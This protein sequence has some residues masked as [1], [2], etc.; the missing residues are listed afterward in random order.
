MSVSDPGGGLPL[1]NHQ[2]DQNKQTPTRSNPNTN[3]KGDNGDP[4]WSCKTCNK[5]TSGPEIPM[6]QCSFCDSTYCL[7]CKK[8]T[9]SKYK[10]LGGPDTMWLCSNTCGVAT[11][12]AI[13]QSKRGTNTDESELENRLSNKIEEGRT[14]QKNFR[15]E[16]FEKLSS[17][18]A[19]IK[20][21]NTHIEQVPTQ[22]AKS[23]SQAVSGTIPNPEG[24]DPPRN[25][26][27]R[28]ILRGA[29]EDQK[30]EDN[31]AEERKRSI[32]I[33]K[34]GESKKENRE[35]RLKEDSDRVKV[36]LD[37][38]KV[39]GIEIINTFRLGIFNA[40]KEGA[41]SLKVSFESE[42]QQQLVMASLKHL[43]DPKLK[44]DEN[45]KFLHNISVSYDLSKNEREEIRILV[46]EA[47]QKSAVSLNS[48]WKVRG[49]PGNMKL[50]QFAKR[51]QTEHPER[52][53][54]T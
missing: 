23:W 42:K 54:E 9:Q 33:H 29:L 4:Q 44:D 11:Q 1:G 15:D 32:V 17:L 47:K 8:I 24:G 31:F 13:D 2:P 34:L 21:Q 16:I 22:V 25:T 10:S 6:L 51:P 26:S 14:E 18:E 27:F 46:E 36:L 41:R 28:E 20:Q 45:T 19:N 50:I 53:Q 38:L 37:V 52:Q 43:G 30:K 40:E 48:V 49:T 5:L 39:D 3:L 12:N 7:P 35:A